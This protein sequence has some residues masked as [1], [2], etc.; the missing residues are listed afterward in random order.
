MRKIKFRGIRV[1]Y[2]EWAYGSLEITH[3][4]KAFIW[5]PIAPLG[6][7][8]QVIPESVGQF[9]GTSDIKGEE[10]YEDDLLQSQVG[11]RHIWQ[12]VFADG[13]FVLEQVGGDKK[14]GQKKHTQDFCCEDDIHLYQ[15]VKIGNIYEN[16]DFFK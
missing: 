16:P 13:S 11:D 6:M 12:I 5:V 10:L 1:G 15:L 3:D 2:D 14:R 4:S 8:T 9:T 7:I